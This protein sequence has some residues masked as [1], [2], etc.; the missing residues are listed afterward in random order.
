MLTTHQFPLVLRLLVLLHSAR[1]N[2][3]DRQGDG[4]Q[5]RVVRHGVPQRRLHDC[6]HPDRR[7]TAQ[8]R[9]PMGSEHHDDLAGGTVAVCHVY[10]CEGCD[11]EAV[12]DAR[13]QRGQRAV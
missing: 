4:L 7:A 2:S 8:S 5:M 3:P 10:A 13:H 1:L 12:H 6:A 11:E 9:D